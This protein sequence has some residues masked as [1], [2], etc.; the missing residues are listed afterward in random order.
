MSQN[1]VHAIT[2]VEISSTVHEFA[3]QGSF[4]NV[5]KWLEYAKT[6]AGRAPNLLVGNK[7]DLD[8]ERVVDYLRAR[9]KYCAVG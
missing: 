2:E 7:C 9:V 1:E 4:Q 5:S 6:Y 8:S 3:W